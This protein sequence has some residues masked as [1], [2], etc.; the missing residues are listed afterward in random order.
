MISDLI[1]REKELHP[2]RKNK[3]KHCLIVGEAG[4][5]KT[6][7]VE[8]ILKQQIDNDEVDRIVWIQSPKTIENVR[9]HLR[10]R[11]LTEGSKVSLVEYISLK[12]TIVVIDNAEKLQDD[13]LQLQGFL[14]EFSNAGVFL[15]TRL[16]HPIPHCLQVALH[17]LSL[18]AVYTLINESEIHNDTNFQTVD[19]A[20]LIW[21]SVGGNPLAIELFIHNWAIFGF[22]SAALLTLDQLFSQ[23]FDSMTI[24][25]HLAWLILVFLT[26]ESL[27]FDSLS[28]VKFLD[29][30][31]ADFVTLGRLC[32]AEPARSKNSN[33]TMPISA[34]QYIQMRYKSSIPLHDLLDQ[35]V[36]HINTMG[37][38]LSDISLTLIE[39]VLSADWVS[40]SENLYLEAL[41]RFWKQGLH[42]GHFT[43][44]FLILG[45][46]VNELMPQNLEVAIG[47]GI[48]QR[49]L[50]QWSH[51]NSVFAAVAQYAGMHGLFTYQAEALLE[52]AVLLRYQG[53][54]AGAVATLDYIDN[55]PE[56]STVDLRFRSVI[57]RVE[58]ALERNKLFDAKS[59][60]TS[61]P[62]DGIR[63]LIFQLEIFAK[64]I[65]DRNEMAFLPALIDKLL[66]DFSSN[67]SMTARIHI[68][69]GRIFQ[70]VTDVKA[71]TKHLIIAQS[72][73]MEI[74]NDP[75]A[76][77]RTQSNLAA[78]L[79]DSDQLLDAHEL[80]KSAENIQRKIGDRV[81]L[82]VTMHNEH[83]LDRKIVN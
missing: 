35:L 24:E 34:S 66:L 25:Q 5:G 19:Y 7:F 10:E 36:A 45:R 20:R 48:S 70:K 62:N 11:L 61:L 67:P 55:L 46:F 4:I 50:G 75:F 37:S 77:A 16:F 63:R 12:K 68:L 73:L 81:G 44:W 38:N 42:R 60:I 33:I 32:I 52:L 64:D 80:L 58:I 59:L 9:T 79:I 54:Y 17:E 22:Q 18:P 6:V 51:A 71:A 1:E 49:C 41:R 21:Q 74:D 14:E 8:Q 57:E 72:M 47:Y 39:S 13:L 82:A 83:A 56:A 29:V 43:K 76:L 69:I 27:D 65:S 78:L 3:L 30:T 40:L 26:D 28:E 31:F 53:D 15:T 2:A 23:L